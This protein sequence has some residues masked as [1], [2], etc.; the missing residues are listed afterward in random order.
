MFG[1]RE[2][3]TAVGGLQ[4][5]RTYNENLKNLTSYTL[6]DTLVIPVFLQLPNQSMLSVNALMDFG[7]SVCFFD[8]TLTHQYNLPTSKKRTPLMVENHYEEI[9]F[10]LIQML[11]HHVILRLSWLA[12]HNSSINWHERILKFPDAGCIPHIQHPS[13]AL[14]TTHISMPERV[15]LAQIFHIAFVNKGSDI[16]TSILLVKYNDFSDVFNKKEA[17]RLPEHRPY[18][19]A[20]DLVSGKQPL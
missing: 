17:N 9:K 12:Y 19:C 6:I 10:N 20:I 4:L 16:A 1:K 13:L 3:P 5:D 2:S 18:N 7:A 15:F 14:T 8:Y 11:H